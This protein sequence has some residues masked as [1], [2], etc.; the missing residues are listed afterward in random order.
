LRWKIAFARLAN[1]NRT[2]RLSAIRPN[3]FGNRIRNMFLGNHPDH[4]LP[5]GK[6]PVLLVTIA[7]AAP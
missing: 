5:R 3:A 4:V 7:I 2:A 6:W 1:S